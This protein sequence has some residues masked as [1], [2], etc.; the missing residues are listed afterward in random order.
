MYKC[1]INI[2]LEHSKY[3]VNTVVKTQKINNKKYLHVTNV[4]TKNISGEI[5]VVHYVN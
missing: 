5:F 3:I 2:S 1:P 4:F